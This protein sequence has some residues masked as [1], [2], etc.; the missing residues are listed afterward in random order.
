MQVGVMHV[1]WMEGKRTMDDGQPR[2]ELRHC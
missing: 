2:F 1:G